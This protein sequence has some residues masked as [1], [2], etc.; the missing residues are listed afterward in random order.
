VLGNLT[1]TFENAA[2]KHAAR[3]DFPCMEHPRG[4]LYWGISASIADQEIKELRVSSTQ[5]RSCWTPESIP[6]SY[7]LLLE[8]CMLPVQGI[9]MSLRK[10]SQRDEGLDPNT[11]LWI[12]LLTLLAAGTS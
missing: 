12:A 3:A 10:Q 8:S 11:T 5:A 1:R 6:S 4:F 9:R 7:V 2:T